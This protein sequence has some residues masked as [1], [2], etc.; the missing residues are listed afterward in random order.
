MA[1]NPD[2]SKAGVLIAVLSICIALAGSG[3][4]P[5]AFPSGTILSSSVTGT[6]T[7]LV[8]AYSIQTALE[9]AGQ[10]SV[11]FG[12]DT[13][14]GRSTAWYPTSANAQI[15]TILVA[16]MRAST[17]YHMRGLAQCPGSATPVAS[18]DQTFT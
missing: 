10:V 8:A 14:Y 3:A 2:L 11:E 6:Q 7:P 16:G 4:G 12:P 15:S 18:P 1:R 9:C 17:T 5:Y 13:T